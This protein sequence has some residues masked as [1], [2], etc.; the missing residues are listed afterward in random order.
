MAFP[1]ALPTPT[2]PDPQSGPSLRWG[3]LGTGWIAEQFVS[4][5]RRT[6]HSVAA[7]GSRSQESAERFVRAHSGG[8]AHGSYAALVADP[9]VDVVYVASPHPQHVEHALLAIAAGKHVLVE[10]PMAIDAAGAARI[11]EAAR[12]AGVFAME[13]MWTLCRPAFSVLSQLLTDGVLGD[14]SLVTADL[15]EYF[16]PEHR[17]FDEALAGGAMMDLGTYPMTFATWVLGAP[18]E[19]TAQGQRGPGGVMAQ[20]TALMRHGDAQSVVHASALAETP[21]RA[22]ISGSDA[23]VFLD[24]LWIKPGGFTLGGRGGQRLRFEEEAIGHG[25]LFWEALE[26]ARAVSQGRTESEIRPLDATIETLAAMDAV[27][28]CTGDHLVGETELT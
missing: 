28:A 24:D 10:K 16:A 7:V 4:S 11:A 8:T 23:Y 22:A 6:N 3:V 17:I 26:V 19:V 5:L 2:V 18:T 20:T 25:G 27:R 12:F 14:I 13:A 9:S 15:G 21:T 1:T